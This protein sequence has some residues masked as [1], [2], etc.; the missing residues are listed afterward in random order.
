M[1]VPESDDNFAIHTLPTTTKTKSGNTVK[2]SEPNS[3]HEYRSRHKHTPP[4]KDVNDDRRSKKIVETVIVQQNNN[5]DESVPVSETS[6]V[7]NMS[8]ESDETELNVGSKLRDADRIIIYKILDSKTQ[9]SKS[10]KKHKNAESILNKGK[11]VISGEHHSEKSKS[12]NF[13]NKDDNVQKVGS[14]EQLQEGM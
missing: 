5:D 6:S 4:T 7:E 2:F 14:F 1:P 3:Y 11:S 10:M 13:E 9:K 8:L 12:G